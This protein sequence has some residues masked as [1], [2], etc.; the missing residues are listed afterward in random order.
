MEKDWK[1]SHAGLVVKDLDKALEGCRAIGAVKT[2]EMQGFPPNIRV[3]F[4]YVGNM[5][6]EIFQPL[7]GKST[8]RDILETRGEGVSHLCYDVADLDKEKKELAARGLTPFMQRDS[9]NGSRL[10]YFAPNGLGGMNIELI[11]RPAAKA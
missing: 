3:I 2:Y 5:E 11:Q 6:L 9:A 4:V 7:E 1:F 10:A 8:I